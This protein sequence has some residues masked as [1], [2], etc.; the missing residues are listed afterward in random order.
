MDYHENLR[1]LS[2]N[3]IFMDNTLLQ[4]LPFERTNE[5]GVLSFFPVCNFKNIYLPFNLVC[6][7]PEIYKHDTNS[8]YLY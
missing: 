5:Q 1:N 4:F 7:L 6:K 3:A 2:K 8:V